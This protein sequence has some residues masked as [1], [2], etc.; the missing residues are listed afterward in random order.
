MLLFNQLIISPEL[1]LVVNILSGT[2]NNI[3]MT[4]GF[5]SV[6]LIHENRTA[7]IAMQLINRRLP[8]FDCVVFNSDEMD[9]RLRIDTSSLSERSKSSHSLVVLVLQDVRTPEKCLE[10]LRRLNFW[11]EIKS[12]TLTFGSPTAESKQFLMQSVT[13][14]LPKTELLV[15]NG[16]DIQLIRSGSFR[17]RFQNAAQITAHEIFQE[18]PAFSFVQS[19]VI[20]TVAVVENPEHVAEFLKGKR[21]PNRIVVELNNTNALLSQIGFK[22]NFT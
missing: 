9:G 8:T 18:H 3:L 5:R 6:M 13:K 21:K 15:W 2:L 14:F 22:N 7:A 4:G 1:V 20:T 17:R 11:F 12:L 16:H 19:H 10:L